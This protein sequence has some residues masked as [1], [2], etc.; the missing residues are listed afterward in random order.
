MVTYIPPTS[1]ITLLATLRRR[2]TLP[3]PGTVVVQDQQKVEP[4]DLIGQAYQPDSY[5]LVNVA[6]RLGV[7]KAD[8]GKY[9]TRQDGDMVK[10]GEVIAK[11]ASLFGLVV[12]TVESRVNGQLVL[13]GDGKALLAS[14]PAPVEV[15]ANLP[16]IITNVIEGLGASVQTT[17]ALMEGAWGN[18]KDAYAVLSVISH[19]PQEPLQA[20]AIEAGLK[21]TLA[22]VSVI[23][24]ASLLKKLLDTEVRGVIVGSMPAEVWPTAQAAKAPVMVTEGFHVRGFNMPAFEFLADASGREAWLNAQTLDWT[25]GQRPELIVPLPAPGQSPPPPADG[26]A[27]TVGARVRVIRGPH[28]G[29]TGQI[30]ALSARAEALPNGARQRVAAIVPDLAGPKTAAL[31]VAFANLMLLE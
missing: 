20:E 13:S 24:E 16:G 6:A 10:K 8:I 19:T 14:I 4:T 7:P 30:V 27:L 28:A 31:S 11:R 25:Q 21:G 9:M 2:R 15:R 18:G 23:P 17:G 22:V 1:H 26:G 5:R 12:D 3:W 29:Q